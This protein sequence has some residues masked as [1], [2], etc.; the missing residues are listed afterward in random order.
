MTTGWLPRQPP[1]LRDVLWAL[2]GAT[3]ERPGGSSAGDV[4][5]GAKR[6]VGCEDMWVCG[7]GAQ[8]TQLSA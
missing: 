3:V 6:Q 5:Q 8:A 1:L 7:L 4:L 2:L